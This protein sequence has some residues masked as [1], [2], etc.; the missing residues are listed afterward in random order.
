MQ[1]L[2]G[3]LSLS[4]AFSLFHSLFL[5][6][7]AVPVQLPATVASG[8]ACCQA[9]SWPNIAEKYYLQCPF[10]SFALR[11]LLLVE[12]ATRTW[13]L[14]SCLTPS[15]TPSPPLHLTLAV[16]DS[17][18]FG[19]VLNAWRIFHILIDKSFCATGLMG[20]WPSLRY[21]TRTLCKNIELV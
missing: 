9:A 15:P 10:A 2:H 18:Q 12:A 8:M 21:C 5:A 13:A 14:Y 19:F 17:F 16:L 3:F 11:K 20:F 4:L 6:V 7:A 1:M